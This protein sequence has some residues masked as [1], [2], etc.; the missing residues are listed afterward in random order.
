VRVHV[1]NYAQNTRCPE[2]CGYCSQS[3]ISDAPLRP[4]AW[5][6]RAELIEEARR[7]HAAGAFRD[8]MVASGR[9]R[10][11]RQIDF[12]CCREGHLRSLGSLALYPA[13]SLFAEGYLTTKGERARH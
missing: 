9:G 5:K 6:P 3:A 7:A 2:D 4:Y 8:C 1:L 12:L 13:N 10:T 11:D